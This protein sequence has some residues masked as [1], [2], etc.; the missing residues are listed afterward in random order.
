MPRNKGY[1]GSYGTNILA[2]KGRNMDIF[3]PTSGDLRRSDDGLGIAFL[4]LTIAPVLGDPYLSNRLT[5]VEFH[6]LVP[7][8]ST[9]QA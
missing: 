5:T 1:G 9:R 6:R 7:S 4:E 2:Q 3:S 8:G